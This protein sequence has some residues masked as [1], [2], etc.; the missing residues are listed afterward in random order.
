MTP[1]SRV[2]APEAQ[3][4]QH[5]SPQSGTVI[6]F[7]TCNPTP[8]ATPVISTNTAVLHCS[9]ASPGQVSPVTRGNAPEFSS[10]QTSQATAASFSSLSATTQANSNEDNNSFKR[11]DC[12][13]PT[14]TSSMPQDVS[15]SLSISPV[16]QVA[17]F[18]CPFLQPRVL[19]AQASARS[20]LPHHP[21]DHVISAL[22][23]L[24]TS[25]TQPRH[26]RRCLVPLG[27][28]LTT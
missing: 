14:A 22:G 11:M 24:V 20:R 23:I 19:M 17:F 21:P 2:N 27:T 5:P 16:P 12:T 1:V 6:V 15:T 9:S 8:W 4:L 25:T 26:H 3:A 28:R 10:L 18:R 7:I 13:P